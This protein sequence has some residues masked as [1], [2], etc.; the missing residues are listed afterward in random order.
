MKSN[1]LMGAVLRAPLAVVLLASAAHGEAVWQRATD[2]V[3]GV[4][5]GSTVN[6]PGTVG[7]VPVWRYESAQGGALGSANP[8]YAQPTT[9]LSWDPGWYQTGWGVWSNGD[10][11]NPPILA[12]RMIHNVHPSTYGQVP[13]VR[14]QSPLGDGGQVNITGS[15]IVNWNGMNG[16]GRPV[17]VDVV[18]AKYNADLNTTTVLFSSTVSKPNPVP[19]VGDSVVLPV[20]L[21]G[22][23]VDQGD[24]LIFSHR[25]RNAV[26][27]L[28][29]WVNLYD[30]ITIQQ[31]PAPGTAGLLAMA[32][33][34]AARRR[35]R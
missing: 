15:M 8:W 4:A 26:G 11:T 28:G 21:S 33:L 35:R 27:P 3:P 6:N 14:W 17:D 2:W 25:G 20:S 34:A 24:Q 18:I 7:G 30:G 9:L 1:G 13:L 19:S 12:G 31:I 29:A 22:I 23:S 10:N 32:G 5:Q 16:L